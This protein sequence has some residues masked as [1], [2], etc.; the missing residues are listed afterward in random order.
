MILNCLGPEESSSEATNAEIS[1]KETS[2]EE[3]FG[4]T[5]VEKANSVSVRLNG[6]IGAVISQKGREN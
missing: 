5:S 6:I 1:L 3:I 2:L 4:E